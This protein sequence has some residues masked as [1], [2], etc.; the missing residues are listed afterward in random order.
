MRNAIPLQ[1]QAIDFRN[2]TRS[3]ASGRH[4]RTPVSPP[5]REI[6]TWVHPNEAS[7]DAIKLRVASEP[8]AQ[9]G[10]EPR[11]PVSPN[12]RDEM[13]NARTVPM[14]LK[15]RVQVSAKT[16]REVPRAHVQFAAYRGA[17]QKRVFQES[18]GRKLNE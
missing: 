6:F 18:A 1:S 11:T 4:E 10:V 8:R 16:S 9:G 15:A 5:T 3:R 14:L 7:E 17:V 13:G 2:T 12:M